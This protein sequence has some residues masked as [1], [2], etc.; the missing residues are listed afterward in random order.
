MKLAFTFPGVG[1]ALTGRE[2]TLLR[3]NQ[4]VTSPLLERASALA[5]AD[6]E[7]AL[8]SDQPAPLSERA[9]QLMTYAFSCAM[10]RAL[11]ANG[12]RPVLAA[13]YSMG[14]YAA[15]ECAGAITF[16]E[17]LAMTAEAHRVMLE[18]CGGGG[19]H[20]LAVTVGITADDLDQLL[21]RGGGALEQ[22][23]LV[24]RNNNTALVCAG[25]VAQLQLLVERALGVDA[26]KAALLPAELPYHHPELMARAPAAFS[27]FL[28]GLSWTRP[29]CPVVS[30]VS[31]EPLVVPEQLIHLTA[32]HLARPIAWP[33]VLETFIRHGVDAAVE[34][35]PGISLTQSARMVPGAP[36]FINVKTVQRRLEI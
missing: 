33:P 15:L 27:P 32:Q 2:A 10:A 31:G 16:D 13:G 8:G 22:V 29:D 19:P 25:P 20:G 1:A 24:N 23:R 3:R 30:A 6:L 11:R 17:G 28:E 9:V 36:A 12:H 18:V 26:I 5:G 4:A 34:C 14:L 7:A 21:T 35:G